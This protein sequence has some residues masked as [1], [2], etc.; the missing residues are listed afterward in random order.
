MVEIRLWKTANRWVSFVWDKQ[1]WQYKYNI[2]GYAA[3]TKKSKLVYMRNKIRYIIKKIKKTVDNSNLRWYHIQAV[4]ETNA[5]QQVFHQIKKKFENKWKKLLTN[6][7]RFDKLDESLRERYMN[8][9]NWTTKQSRKFPRWWFLAHARAGG[10][11]GGWML[12]LAQK[13]TICQMRTGVV[14]RMTEIDVTDK[15][16]AFGRRHQ[17]KRKFQ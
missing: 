7:K 11:D 9:D 16:G 1:L 10:A 2:D 8:F 13:Q 14:R 6:F 17:R 5:K 12:A 3:I 4:S 15:S